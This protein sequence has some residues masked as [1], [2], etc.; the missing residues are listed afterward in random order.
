MNDRR[1][2]LR[3]IEIELSEIY[4][5]LFGSDYVPGLQSS[6]REEFNIVIETFRE[7][8]FAIRELQEQRD[9]K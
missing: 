7:R 2:R 3:T 8:I 1:R 5:D 4:K 6:D 9:R